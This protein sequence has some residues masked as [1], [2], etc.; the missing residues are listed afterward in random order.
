M[1]EILW[2]AVIRFNGD[3]ELAFIGNEDEWK[4]D[5]DLYFQS[6]TDGDQFIDC[7]DYDCDCTVAC[8]GNR[9]TSVGSSLS[10]RTMAMF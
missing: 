1:D 8:G 5:A 4:S 10:S 7:D 9:S 3:D 6:Y 2:P